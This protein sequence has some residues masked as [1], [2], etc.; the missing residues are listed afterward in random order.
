MLPA[1]M[2]WPMTLTS[3][4]EAIRREN[5]AEKKLIVGEK[6]RHDPGGHVR[7]KDIITIN[8]HKVL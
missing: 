5:H 4:N 1:N 3:T 7:C 8:K 2:P 6:Y